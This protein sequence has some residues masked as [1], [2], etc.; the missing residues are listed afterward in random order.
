MELKDKLGGRI[1]LFPGCNELL[2]I[3]PD[4]LPLCSKHSKGMTEFYA[5]VHPEDVTDKTYLRGSPV[6]NDDWE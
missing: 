2:L 5:K 3:R 6:Y 4:K 1:C